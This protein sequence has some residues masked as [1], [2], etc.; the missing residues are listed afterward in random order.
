MRKTKEKIYMKKIIIS[1]LAT[2]WLSANAFAETLLVH[3]P[4]SK[5]GNGSSLTRFVTE[6][7]AEKGWN[8]DYKITSNCE[9]T[10]ETWEKAKGPMMIVWE[11]DFMKSQNCNLGKVKRS[12]F[13]QT[14]FSSAQF[15]CSVNQKNTDL[16]FDKTKEAK[17]GLFKG[18]MFD[19]YW[20]E[21]NKQS[22]TKHKIAYYKNS[23]EAITALLSGEIDYAWQTGNALMKSGQGNCFINTT[24]QE[25]QGVQPMISIFP[26][27]KYSNMPQT[28]WFQ[29]KNVSAKELA[30]LRADVQNIQKTKKEFVEWANKKSYI[31]PFTSVDEQIKTL[32]TIRV[33]SK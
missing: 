11:G 9:L 31:V 22:Q 18:D 15:I 13:V 25:A 12:Q 33:L 32:E 27:F 5:T 24:N 30:R 29:A 7:L 3:S 16:L 17:I 20:A 8:V 19:K 10:K 2:V 21:L 28:V 6:G 4:F 26:N 1:L 23:D 14:T